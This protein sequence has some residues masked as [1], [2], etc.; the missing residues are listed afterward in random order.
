[1]IRIRA[2]K[3]YRVIPVLVSLSTV[4][5][6]LWKVVVDD[7]PVNF[8]AIVV[9]ICTCVNIKCCC[10]STKGLKFHFRFRRI[11]FVVRA[12]K[13]IALIQVSV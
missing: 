8:T 11:S 13:P 7:T 1:M 12:E 6:I 5:Y 4:S 3:S 9:N 10:S 2:D